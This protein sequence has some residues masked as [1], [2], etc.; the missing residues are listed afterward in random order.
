MRISDWSSDVCSSVLDRQITF[1]DHREI[2]ARQGLQA[3]AGAT[4][5]DL[6]LALSRTQRYLASFGQL[7]NNIE[8]GMRRNSARAGRVHSSLH[9][10]DARQ[11]KIGRPQPA[12]A[13]LRQ[14]GRASC[15]ERGGQ[16]LYMSVVD[17][18]YKQKTL[19]YKVEIVI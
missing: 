11:V 3:E 2:V 14:I 5:I 4:R 18:R 10:I 13:I 17:A 7:T 15:R 8:P 9:R 12:P 16:Y 1:R 19:N 6:H